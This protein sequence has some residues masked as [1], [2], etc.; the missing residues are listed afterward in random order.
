MVRAR[1]M[2]AGGLRARAPPSLLLARPTARKAVGRGRPESA[3][4]S[5][6]RPAFQRWG[7][8]GF[9]WVCVLFFYLFRVHVRR[10]EDNLWEFLFFPSR[11]S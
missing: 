9:L 5:V 11:G 1:P 8:G 2:R 4:P 6:S 3:Q 10:S 7:H